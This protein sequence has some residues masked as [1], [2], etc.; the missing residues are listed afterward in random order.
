MLQI[1]SLMKVFLFE[2]V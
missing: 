2:N 1:F